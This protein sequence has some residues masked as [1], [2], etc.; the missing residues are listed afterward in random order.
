MVGS[1]D[2]DFKKITK[3]TKPRYRSGKAA[4]SKKAK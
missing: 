2:A 1:G 3:G 4:G